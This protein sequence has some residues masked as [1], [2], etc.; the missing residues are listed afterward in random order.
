[1]KIHHKIIK[2]SQWI[3]VKKTAHMALRHKHG[4]I[5]WY[6]LWMVPNIYYWGSWSYLHNTS[7]VF[8]ELGILHAVYCGRVAGR[9]VHSKYILCTC[10][11]YVV[12]TIIRKRS[13]RAQKPKTPSWASKPLFRSVT[14]TSAFLFFYRLFFQPVGFQG[15]SLTNIISLL[16]VENFNCDWKMWFLD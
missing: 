4:K 13:P 2:T 7:N 8:T 1:M 10:T 15:V 12:C 14:F 3:G 6:L 5:C 16:W 11:T 9:V